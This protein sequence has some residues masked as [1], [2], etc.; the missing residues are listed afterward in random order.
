MRR[1]SSSP[2]RYD[3][4]T[5]R[6]YDVSFLTRSA[7]RDFGPISMIHF[8]R[9]SSSQVPPHPSQ[10]STGTLQYLFSAIA[11]PQP[12]Q[13]IDSPPEVESIYDQKPCPATTFRECPVSMKRRFAAR[14]ARRGFPLP[15]TRRGDTISAPGA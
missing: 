4:E 15:A 6:L 10:V 7:G 13:N 11:P 1:V 12:E 9:P 8:R 5:G 3:G 14:A 2:R